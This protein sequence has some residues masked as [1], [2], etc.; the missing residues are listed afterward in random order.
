MATQFEQTN[1]SQTW[2][3]VE[4]MGHSSYGGLLREVEFCG[5]KFLEVTVPAQENLNCEFTMR[6]SPSAI[7]RMC[8]TT[9]EWARKHDSSV[10]DQYRIRPSTLRPPTGAHLPYWGA[11][12]SGKDLYCDDCGCE[13]TP[14]SASLHGG[15]CADC[16][17]EANLEEP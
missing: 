7:F 15:R 16:H 5:Q 11:P 2:G 10:P 4:V 3:I 17:A 9:E 14:A 1:E 12:P 13:I 6:V 8:E